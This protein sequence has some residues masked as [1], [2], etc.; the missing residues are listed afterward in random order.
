MP[1]PLILA[2]PAIGASVIAIGGAWYYANEA[3]D[4]WKETT[5]EYAEDLLD[6]GY[7]F[8]G[9]IG[10]EIGE[11]LEVIGEALGG[12]GSDIGNSLL[13][14]IRYLGIAV[15]EGME[16][17]YQ[18]IAGKVGGKKVQITSSVTIL[19]IM[20]FTA[21]YIFARLPSGGDSE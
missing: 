20:M 13:G 12:L 18:Y 21:F 6:Q 7:D 8:L 16:D 10:E 1:I 19:G 4:D 5:Q 2:A 3:G 17:T 15:I 9:D 11:G 14:L